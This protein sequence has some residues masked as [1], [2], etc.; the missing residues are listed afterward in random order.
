[1]AAAAPAESRQRCA[2]SPAHRTRELLRY[3]LAGGGESG[4]VAAAAAESGGGA[5]EVGGCARSLAAPS[6]PSLA[7]RAG[8]VV[9][10]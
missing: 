1:M 6:G 5:A 9:G 4:L 10:S 7:T 8:A 3:P 2:L